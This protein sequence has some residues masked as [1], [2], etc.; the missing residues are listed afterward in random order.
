MLKATVSKKASVKTIDNRYEVTFNL[1]L[2]DD[3]VEV[4]NQDFTCRHRVGDALNGKLNFIGLEMQKLIN[5][6]KSGKAVF[7]STV[8][9]NAVTTIQ[10][11][12]TV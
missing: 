3:D 2:T 8:L 4:L 6:Y 5:N 10:N 1:K 11:K 9:N 12:L 7:D